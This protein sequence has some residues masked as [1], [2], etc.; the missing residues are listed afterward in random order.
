GDD[1]YFACD[2][3]KVGAEVHRALQSQNALLSR[4]DSNVPE[5]FLIGGLALLRRQHHAHAFL[6][7]YR[8]R[9]KVHAEAMEHWPGAGEAAF[10]Q[11]HYVEL[12]LERNMA[13]N[14]GDL[15]QGERLL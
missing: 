15:T 11:L 13:R 10:A 4:F 8:H 14:A 3:L 7:Q 12:I 2:R 9:P 1:K 5:H 6:L